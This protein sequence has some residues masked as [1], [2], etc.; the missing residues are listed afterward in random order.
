MTDM[1][2]LSQ[3]AKDAIAFSYGIDTPAKARMVE[4]FAANPKEKPFYGF[5][6]I[7]VSK[8][9][10]ANVY[11]HVM[12]PKSI[13]RL[14]TPWTGDVNVAR[15]VKMAPGGHTC[16]MEEWVI[17]NQGNRYT[18]NVEMYIRLNTGETLA[19]M[20]HLVPPS[21]DNEGFMDSF[22]EELRIITGMNRKKKRPQG[23]HQMPRELKRVI[24]FLISTPKRF[25]IDFV[26][27]HKNILMRRCGQIVITDPLS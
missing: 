26:E 23:Y 24:N 11:R 27:N 9:A 4:A 5:L 6:A 1:P 14:S 7:R 8:G 2:E 15:A 13:I 21:Q 20:E 19:I 12:Y 25:R 16:Y 10:F 22:R 18:P 3:E 17:P